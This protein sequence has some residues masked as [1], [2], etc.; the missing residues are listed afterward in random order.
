MPDVY[1]TI[2]SAEPVLVQRI[3]RALDVRGADVQQKRM[4]G[5]YLEEITF[6]TDARV[7]ENWLRDRSSG[8]SARGLAAGRGDRRG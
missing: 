7:I 4:L 5:S 6:P 8:T 2:T 1:N 3:A